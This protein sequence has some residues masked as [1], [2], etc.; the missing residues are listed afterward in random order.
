MQSSQ[1]LFL[2]GAKYIYWNE[3]SAGSDL[4]MHSKHST[5][6]NCANAYKTLKSKHTLYETT[7]ARIK[8][9]CN[10]GTAWSVGKLLSW[11]GGGGGGNCGIFLPNFVSKTATWVAN[12]VDPD[13]TPQNT[14]LYC[15]LQ[16]DCQNNKGKYASRR[17][18]V[19]PRPRSATFFVEI[20]YEIFSTVILSLPLIQEGQ[21]SVS[22]E[23]M[24]TI[25]V[26]SFE[27]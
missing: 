7:D 25:L 13:Q 8:K 1:G 2:A 4:P 12:S 14:G 20:D 11:G 6:G 19:Q 27:V 9:S 10:G 5:I 15:L 17:S 23:R 24:C 22:G 16:S 26:N 18:R 3:T 21:L